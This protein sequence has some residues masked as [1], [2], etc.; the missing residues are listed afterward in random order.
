MK[1]AFVV[2]LQKQGLLKTAV[3][4][5]L[6]SL[7][8]GTVSVQAADEPVASASGPAIGFGVGNPYALR[9]SHHG[10]IPTV[11]RIKQMREWAAMHSRSDFNSIEDAVNKAV[12]YIGQG[13]P[14]LVYQGGN[15]GVGVM[16]GP[17]KVYLVFYGSQW[18]SQTV[19]AK[20]DAKFSG[21]P[22]SA[23]SAVQEMF[24]G[25]GTNNELWQ[26]D[27]TQWCDGPNIAKGATACPANANFVPYQKNL[28]AGVWYDN[29]AASPAAAT[30]AQIAN[31]AIAAAQHFGNTTAAS[32][33][34]SYYIILSPHGTNP[35]SYQG[36]YCAYHDSTTGMGINS[37]YGEIAYSNQ[38]YNTD[39][40]A[41]C[42]VG[43]VNN[44][45]TLDG[46]TMTLGHEWHEMMSDTF[47]AN[48]SN[49]YGWYSTTWTADGINYGGENSD[50]CAWIAPGRAGGAQNIAFATGTFAEQASWSNDTQSCAISHQIVAHGGGTP[51]A[52]FSSS[53]SGLTA[54][55]VDTSTD[56]GGQIGSH[57]WT[58]GDGANSTAANPSHTYAAAGTYNVT[59][60]VTDSV[61]GKTSSATK[62]VSVSSATGSAKNIVAANS[63]L[64]LNVTNNSQG[65]GVVQSTCGTTGNLEWKLV[66]VG[67]YYHIV[68]QG[69]GL[70]LNVPGSS[71]TA[72]TQLIQWGCQSSGTYNDQWSLVSVGSNY[73]IVS[74]SSGL[75]VNISGYSG[76]A[77][78]QVI[79]WNCQSSSSLNDQFTFH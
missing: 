12:P 32:N 48:G 50:E 78:A 55:F 72:G 29:S 24:K 75:C 71:T 19:D 70:C 67:S 26:A 52:S 2:R 9:S 8:A 54:S 31:I 38:P 73:H 39:S 15:N 3:L 7:G 20:G 37:P 57:S 30:G 41:G 42:G 74:R 13:D 43:F 61:S 35:D 56:N 11:E 22:D 36:N 63:S 59:E 66:A 6:L 18:G 62:A 5:A 51:A 44:P 76:S 58:F 79:Q 65:T 46:Y 28:L 16:S 69:S 27:L 49:A 34:Y 23:A 77:G 45:G 64:C 40:G 68:A 47:F 17:V 25:I 14:T 60:T 21:D 53:T 33:R 4:S 10:V 1:N